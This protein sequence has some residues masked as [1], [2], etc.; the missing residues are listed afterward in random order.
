MALKRRR[1]VVTFRLSDE[2]YE[3][4]KLHCFEAEV[5]SISEFSRAAVL[6][7]LSLVSAPQGLLVGNL[8]LVTRE[9]TGLD[10]ALAD[11]RDHIRR[12]LGIMGPEQEP[13]ANV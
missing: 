7:R 13:K 10:K 8:G 5:R 3:A 1:R 9:L 6:D 2:E 12:V 11:L 4:L